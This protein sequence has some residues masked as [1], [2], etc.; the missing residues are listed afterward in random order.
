MRVLILTSINPAIAGLAYSQVVN[1][2]EKKEKKLNIICFPFFAEM[3]VR[4]EDKEYLPSLFS[5][6]K[7]S[8]ETD[9]QRKI[10]NKKNT[11]VIGNTYKDQK[12]DFIVAY[13]DI[14]NEPFD[15]Y[16]E[17]IR[18]D[19]RF[20]EFKKLVNIDNL[21]SPEDASLHLPTIDHVMLFLFSTYFDKN[22]L[23]K[24]V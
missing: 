18:T 24:A 6:M 9:M 20:E 22:E 17:T 3:A 8:L 21:Y 2:F 13:D 12:F 4:T 15:S 23:H 11:V 14:S 1:Y 5:M 16:I 10:Y 7:N 19:E